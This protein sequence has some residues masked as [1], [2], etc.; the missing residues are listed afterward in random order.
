MFIF[1][2]A[3]LSCP[4]KLTI[5]IINNDIFSVINIRGKAKKISKK[6]NIIEAK[7][8]NISIGIIGKTKI[9]G[10]KEITENSPIR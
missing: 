1:N 7:E 10:I 6:D 3:K 9:F 4:K 2:V 8:T 5:S